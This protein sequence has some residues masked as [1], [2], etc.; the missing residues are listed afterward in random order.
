M[1]LT[2]RERKAAVEALEYFLKR[3][4]NE[5]NYADMVTALEKLLGKKKR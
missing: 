1:K 3:W 2:E 4:P 5:D